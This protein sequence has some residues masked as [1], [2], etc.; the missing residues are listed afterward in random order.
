MRKK[1]RLIIGAVALTAAVPLLAQPRGDEPI[2]VPSSIK[3]G[4]DFV[5]VDPDMSSVAIKQ[6]RPRNWLR[7]VFGG[8]RDDNRSA[9]RIAGRPRPEHA[10]ERGTAI[11]VG[12]QV[13]IVER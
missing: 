11:L 13:F 8:S 2:A 9:E 7:R 12:D 4:V 6:R 3:Q 5:Y 1:F 10:I